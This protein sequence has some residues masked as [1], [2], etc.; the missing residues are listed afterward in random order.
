MNGQPRPVGATHSL[1]P[2]LTDPARLKRAARA[3]MRAASTPGADGVTWKTYRDHLD[4]RLAD[5]ARQLASGAWQPAPPVIAEL[6][7]GEKTVPVV[8]PTVEDRI[9]H[10][11]IRACVEPILD[12]VA[13]S[14]WMFGW[15]PGHSR[16]NALTYAAGL[17]P[18]G[19]PAW[20]ADVDVAAVT[21]GGTV[22]EAVGSLARWIYD[23]TFLD[24]VRR[25]LNALP[26]TLSPGCGLTP[27]LTNLRLL[28]VDRQLDGLAVVRVTDNY[29]AFCPDQTAAADAQARIVAAL[30]TVDLR[31]NQTKSKIWQPNL[32]DLFLA[33]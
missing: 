11:A 9:V 18:A 3:S 21:R 33:G 26:S 20:V 32:E 6:A 19:A 29:A 28:P 31:P 22:D 2:L 4:A 12:T 25:A 10:R 27:M 5:L 24:V 14:E 17:S 1:M 8:I 30:A 13:Y 16:V 7:V 23:G 15:R